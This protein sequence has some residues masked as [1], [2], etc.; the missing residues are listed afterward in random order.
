VAKLGDTHRVA[1]DQHVGHVAHPIGAV[2]RGTPGGC[3]RAPA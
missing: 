3:S 1:D 2:L